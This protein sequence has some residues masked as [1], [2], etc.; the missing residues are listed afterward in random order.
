MKSAVAS[1]GVVK[2]FRNILAVLNQQRNIGI[3]VMSMA[4][5]FFVCPE[6]TK[7]GYLAV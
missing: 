3:D 4:F 5:N 6:A 1:L 2:K 7:S